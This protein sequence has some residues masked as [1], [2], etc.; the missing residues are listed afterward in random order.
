[1][2]FTLHPTLA[3]DSDLAARVGALQI[4]LMD[5]SRYFWLIIVPETDAGE[6]HDLEPETATA[7]WVAIRALGQ[8]LKDHTNADKINAAAIGNMVPQL[9][10][11]LVA[12]H[13]GD[14]DWPR[15]IW[16]NGAPT[17][18]PEANKSMRLSIIQ[19]WVGSL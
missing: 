9:H 2:P 5:D 1:M 8:R 15:P 16:G 13:V 6:L 18:L 17:P 4:R 3:K 12:R 10:F 14:A 19:S 7:L 11:H